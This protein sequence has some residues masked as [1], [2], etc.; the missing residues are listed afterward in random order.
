[1]TYQRNGQ[2][3]A[4][5]GAREAS[6]GATR[7][8]AAQGAPQ[9]IAADASAKAQEMVRIDGYQQVLEMLRIADDEFRRSLLARLSRQA[10]DLAAALKKELASS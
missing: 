3:N 1:M 10:P 2:V 4:K 6:G 5:P 8:A 9:G 7:A